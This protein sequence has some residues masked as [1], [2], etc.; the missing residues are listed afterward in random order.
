MPRAIPARWVAWAAQIA[1][2]LAVQ[3]ALEATVPAAPQSPRPARTPRT[4]TFIPHAAPEGRYGR[5]SPW[6]PTTAQFAYADGGGI[7]VLNLAEAN[8]KPVRIVQAVDTD[9]TWSPD[10]TWL[11]VR[12]Q[13]IA[14]D[15]EGAALVVVAATGGAPTPVADGV[16]LSDF[17]WAGDGKI[18]YWDYT[19]PQPHIVEPP[20][21]WAAARGHTLGARPVLVFEFGGTLPRAAYF[22]ARTPKPTV[23]LAGA[24]KLSRSLLRSDGFADGRL[25]VHVLSDTE[26]TPGANLLVDATGKTAGRIR[27]AWD[28]G[29]FTATSVSSDGTY[30]AG[31]QVMG[32][33]DQVTGSKIFLVAVDGSWHVGVSGVAWG[34]DPRLSRTGNYLA[35]TD[36]DGNA[37]IGALQLQN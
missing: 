29:V 27:A 19:S 12:T 21:A 4:A 14:K 20:A 34:A 23:A 25:L 17:V 5:Y 22:D 15:A 11:L 30:A 32:D 33:E 28:E 3:A 37:H 16:L 18:Y 6:S 13:A 35:Y 1:L 10:G 7:L 8:A 2:L 24:A 26:G 31:E 9:C 36:A